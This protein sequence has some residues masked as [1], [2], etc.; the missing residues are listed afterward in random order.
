MPPLT[1]HQRRVQADKLLA[2]IR[3][4]N[5]N[6][7]RR[8]LRAHP[9]LATIEDANGCA[10]LSVVSA[11]GRF[12]ILDVSVLINHGADV[13]AA[14]ASDGATPLFA[15]SLEGRVPVVECLTSHGADVNAAAASDRVMPLHAASHAGHLPVLECLV[16]HGADVDAASSIGITPLNI[17]SRQGHLPVVQCLATNGADVDAAASNR[18]TPL[19]AAS[20]QGHMPVV[21]YLVK[22]AGADLSDRV[23]VHA[24]THE[25]RSWSLTDHRWT[26]DADTRAYLQRRMTAVVRTT[27]RVATV[28]ACKVVY[29]CDDVECQR[30]HG[31]RRAIRRDC[32]KMDDDED[33]DRRSCV[34][35]T[36]TR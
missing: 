5:V 32:M 31:R 10:P 29:Y 27:R 19:F 26:A 16:N 21:K 13:N 20:R 12:A 30:A 22:Y 11:T 17:A 6:V 34:A 35:V 7:V 23:I 4:D 14:A 2:A 36:G 25:R 18:V 15:A 28:R 1:A 33:A 3:A 9:S 8:L 24:V